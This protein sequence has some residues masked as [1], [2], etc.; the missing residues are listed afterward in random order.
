M[1][2]DTVFAVAY[3]AKPTGMVCV[4]RN[5]VPSELQSAGPSLRNLELAIGS[6]KLTLGLTGTWFASPAGLE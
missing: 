1:A 6:Q 3:A 4:T 5:G 2:A